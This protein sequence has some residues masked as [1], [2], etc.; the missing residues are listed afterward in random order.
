MRLCCPM[1]VALPFAHL[2]QPLVHNQGVVLFVSRLYDTGAP[3]RL[4]HQANQ[5]ILNIYPG[6][7][8]LVRRSPSEK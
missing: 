3:T 7:V 5:P 2:L 8:V 6:L 1:S 4:L